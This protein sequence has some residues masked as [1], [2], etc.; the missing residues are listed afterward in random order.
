[1]AYNKLLKK[2]KKVDRVGHS[3]ISELDFIVD[4]LKFLNVLSSGAARELC[5][6]QSLSK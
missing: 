5:I 1:M 4:S 3:D 2:T 6:A